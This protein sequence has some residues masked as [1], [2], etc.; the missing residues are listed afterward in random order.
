MVLLL[1]VI[2]LFLKVKED[3]GLESAFSLLNSVRVQCHFSLLYGFHVNLQ[4]RLVTLQEKSSDTS[5]YLIF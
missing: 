4:L 2:R 1:Q 3:Y 5:L